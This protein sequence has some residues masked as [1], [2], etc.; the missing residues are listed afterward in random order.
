MPCF[1][2]LFQKSGDQIFHL[3][4]DEENYF[5]MK[6]WFLRN[7]YKNATVQVLNVE[8]LNLENQ[9]KAI[10]YPFLPSE[11]LVSFNSID[12]TPKNYT[13]T[14]Y[15][16]TFSHLHF[17]L[18]KIFQNLSKVVVLDDDVV[19]QQDLSALWG[20]NMRGKVNGVVPFCS[21]TLGQIKSYLGESNFSKNSCAWMSGLSIID[22]KRWRELDLTATYQRLV[23]EVRGS[24]LFLF[25]YV[26][27]LGSG[28]CLLFENND[29]INVPFFSVILFLISQN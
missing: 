3:L 20:L 27:M 16:S 26:D 6:F 9:D 10:L 21:V 4:T 17:Q 2:L 1:V 22:L 14:R 25:F 29:D 28:N 15:I 11:Y 23:Q 5:A 18:P 13:R 24:E 8:H 19:V 7:T 12:Y